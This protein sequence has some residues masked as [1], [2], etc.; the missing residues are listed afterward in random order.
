MIRKLFEKYFFFI[1]KIE[2]KKKKRRRKFYLQKGYYKRKN[3]ETK[4][5]L[6][7]IF[8]SIN[9]PLVSPVERCRIKVD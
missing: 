9:Y 3:I 2:Y 5:E 4:T 6:F 7:Y 1:F 8:F